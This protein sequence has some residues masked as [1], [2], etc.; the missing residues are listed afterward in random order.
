MNTLRTMFEHRIIS[1][2]GDISCPVSSPDLSACDFLSWCYLKSKVFQ[3]RPADLHSL[4]HRISRNHYIPLAMLSVWTIGGMILTGKTKVL[5][6]KPVI[7]PLYPPK[8]SHEL[9]WDRTRA[10]VVI[11]LR[12]VFINYCMSRFYI[13]F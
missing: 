9:A 6:E 4:K 7:V 10:S 3:A 12:L 5:K 11:R 8:T 1:R 13:C 2:Y